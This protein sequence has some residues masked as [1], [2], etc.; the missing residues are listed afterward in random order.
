MTALADP[1]DVSE[2]EFRVGST[3]KDG[4]RGMA[5][6]YITARAV[7]NRLDECCGVGGWAGGLSTLPPR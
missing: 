3:N 1:F 7:M 5:L 4:T 6:T 2:V